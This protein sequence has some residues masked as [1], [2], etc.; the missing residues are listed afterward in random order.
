MTLIL[1]P[2]VV[3]LLLLLIASFSIA[4]GVSAYELTFTPRA[5]ASEEYTTN[6]FL[7]NKDEKDDFITITSAGFTARWI[8]RDSEV[9]IS[10]DPAY[11]Y[12]KD[13]DGDEDDDYQVYQPAAGVQYEISA[14]ASFASR[15][16]YFYQNVNGSDNG[17]GLVADGSISKIWSKG[18]FDVVG[19]TGYTRADF[20]AENLGYEEFYRA[21]SD[22]SY[23]FTRR[24]NADFFG[25]YRHSK[26]TETEDNRKDDVYRVGAGLSFQILH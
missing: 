6:V 10:Y 11:V 17:D 22:V 1:K 8:E 14:D 13:F 26:F 25:S 20:G 9:E 24:I 18:S 7:D 16:G 3:F 12:Y 5:S 15:V 21:R 2:K 19:S 4:A 23:A